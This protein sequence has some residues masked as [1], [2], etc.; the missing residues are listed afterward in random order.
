MSFLNDHP[1][2]RWIAPVA[3][4]G[5]IGATSVVTTRTASADSGLP[6]RTAAQLLADVQQARLDSLSGTIVQTSDLGLPE[7]PGV[8]STASGGG[9]SSSLT[10]MLSGTH[11]WR[12]W[13]AGPTTSRTTSV[14]C[15]SSW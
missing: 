9:G 12:A 13:Y 4:V 5:L 14:T 2:L 10:S 7:L 6:P 11:T 8:G 15:P 3:A 1:R